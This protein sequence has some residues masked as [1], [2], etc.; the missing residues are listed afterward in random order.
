M[1]KVETKPN[2][3]YVYAVICIM[4]SLSAMVYYPVVELLNRISVPVSSRA[5]LIYNYA[6]F[7]ISIAVSIMTV[8]SKKGKLSLGVAKGVGLIILVTLLF[9]IYG[10]FY[11]QNSQYFLYFFLWAVPALFV[12]MFVPSVDNPS[13]IKLLEPVILIM[14]IASTV[15][16]VRYL[17]AGVS[18]LNQLTYGGTN[19]QG[20]S[21]TGAFCVGMEL[22]YIFIAS[23]EKRFRIFNTK[24]GKITEI[25]FGLG[26]A[27]S[28]FVSGGRGGLVLLILNVLVFFILLKQ[29]NKYSRRSSRIIQILLIAL[30]VLLVAVLFRVFSGNT[31][32]SDSVDRLLSYISPTA[33]SDMWNEGRSNIYR[34]AFR[35]IADNPI[36]GYGFFN[37]S[38]L[39]GEPYPHNFLLETWMNAG[40]IYL[41][42]WLFIIISLLRFVIKLIKE[43][44][45]NSWVLLIL[46][47]AFAFLS[48][49]GT[50]LWCSQ[51]WFIIGVMLSGKKVEMRPGHNYN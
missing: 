39:N 29:K 13:V 27:L 38:A 37:S 7:G 32:V 18:H 45:D 9:L 15:A 14:G 36:Y 40:F 10:L 34:T 24:A 33:K 17:A 8:A 26:A 25:L 12:G 31:L 42:L 47:Y 1:G 21:Y 35:A 6:V 41:A 22:Y 50:Y 43:N 44:I 11:R 20:L 28:V 16:S 2:R 23:E 4:A 5:Y 48:V 19:Y 51:F 30:I 46:T 49:S 3:G